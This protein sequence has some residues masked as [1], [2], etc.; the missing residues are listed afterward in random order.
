M[1][2]EKLEKYLLWLLLGIFPCLFITI[3]IGTVILNLLGVI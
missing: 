1:K 3:I 2:I